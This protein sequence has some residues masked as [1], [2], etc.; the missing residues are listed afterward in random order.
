[1]TDNLSKYWRTVV[2]T[3][4]D[5]LLVVDP[6]GTVVSMNE[7]AE[8]LTGYSSQELLGKSCT[9]LKCTGCKVF[10]KGKAKHWC[11]LFRR[12]N[13]RQKRCQITN[14][15]GETV[16]IVKQASILKDDSGQVLGAVETLTDVSE[17]I[18]KDNEINSLRRVLRA[19]EGFHGI[20]GKS[21]P[22]G[23]LFHFIENAA[24]SDAPVAIYGESGTGKELV[25]RAIHELS[26]RRNK[27]FVK[28]NCAALNENLLESELFGH[29]K[30]AFTGAHQTR[31]GRFEAAHEGAIFLD[32]IGDVP[33]STQVKLLRA[34]EEKEIERVGDHRPIRVDVRIITATHQNLERLIGQGTFRKDF[35]YRINV[36][37]LHVPPL[38]HRAEDVPLLAHAFCERVSLKEGEP[39]KTISPEAMDLLLAYPWPGNVRELQSAIEYAY[40]LANGNVIE[41]EHLPHKLEKAPL[42]VSHELKPDMGLSEREMLIEA[43]KRARGNQSEA[44]RLL[45]VSRVTVWKRMKK[46]GISL[47]RDLGP[48]A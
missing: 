5:G 19:E 42:S 28:V 16:Q 9:T 39:V 17:I 20:L 29:V 23:R 3:M 32:E 47:T 41:P 24:R 43:L 4:L 44:A 48:D 36:I 30:G 35:F 7:A 38:R 46:H 37:P 18:R 12:G 31:V 22:M 1:M 21:E 26:D 15:A 45:G 14:K 6:S 40:V 13:V 33:A 27:P 8:A 10:G 2:D 34:L 25:A 11:S